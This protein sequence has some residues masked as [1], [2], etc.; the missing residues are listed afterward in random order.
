VSS[1]GRQGEGLSSGADL[2]ED[3]RFVAFDSDAA[4]LVRGDRNGITDVFR[5]DRTTGQT[6]LVSL[7]TDGRQ[8]DASS[9]APA[10]SADGRFIV[11]H[12]NSSLT[13]EDTNDTTDVYVRDVQANVTTLV[14]IG[15]DGTAGNGTSFIQDISADDRFVAFVSSATNLIPERCR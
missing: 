10:I 1:R 9:H 13:P 8:G 7:S 15:F 2:S 3:G 4:N 11:F 12:A 14:S 6:I 5:H